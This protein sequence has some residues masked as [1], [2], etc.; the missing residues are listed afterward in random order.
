MIRVQ[1]REMKENWTC[2]KRNGKT[3]FE[4]VENGGS[5]NEAIVK[6]IYG[7]INPKGPDYLP[8]WEAY[9]KIAGILK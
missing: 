6:A 7:V 9:Q 1:L 2:Q 5:D 4:C 8:R 3:C